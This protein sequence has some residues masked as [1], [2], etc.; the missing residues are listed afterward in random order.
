VVDGAN[1]RT[2]HWLNGRLGTVALKD[3]IAMVLEE[4]G[5][6]AFDVDRVDGVVT[7]HVI[8]NP[9]SP[10]AALA[11]LLEAFAIDVRE[12]PRGLEFCSR[13]GAGAAPAQI[14]VVADPDEG[15]AV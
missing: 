7:G 5:F 6:E 11:P 12:G 10:R 15:G 13:L 3:L 4:A 8:S 1:W 14:D 9:L 2:G